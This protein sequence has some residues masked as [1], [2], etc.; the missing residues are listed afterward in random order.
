MST[1]GKKVAL[2]YESPGIESLLQCLATVPLACVLRSISPC[3]RGCFC[4]DQC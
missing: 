1:E 3:I 2:E 4:E